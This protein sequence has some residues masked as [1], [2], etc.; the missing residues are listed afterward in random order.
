MRMSPPVANFC[1]V[2]A[3]CF[4]LAAC[5]QEA[6]PQ[7]ESPTRPTDASAPGANAATA[8]ATGN[9][10]LEGDVIDMTLRLDNNAG[11]TGKK[12]TAKNLNLTA[13][14]YVGCE[15]WADTS[16]AIEASGDAEIRLYGEPKIELKRF[17]DRAKLLKKT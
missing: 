6:A 4:S 15:I 17:A 5:R 12:L 14:G 2:A 9:P 13:E 1:L 10:A 11:F 7:V 8:N 3:I 16:I